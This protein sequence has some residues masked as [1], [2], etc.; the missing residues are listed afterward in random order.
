MHEII[1][2]SSAGYALLS[3]VLTHEPEMQKGDR[4]DKMSLRTLVFTVVRLGFKQNDR[5]V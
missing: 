4:K 2:Q 3:A 5:P 1:E